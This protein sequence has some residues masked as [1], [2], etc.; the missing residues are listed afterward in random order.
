M[1]SVKIDVHHDL[2]GRMDR[3]LDEVVFL[4]P[5]VNISVFRCLNET[6]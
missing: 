4:L 5:F 2:D 3:I 6:F 1:D